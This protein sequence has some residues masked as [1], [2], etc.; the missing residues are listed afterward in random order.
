M[1]ILNSTMYDRSRQMLDVFKSIYQ[2][3]LLT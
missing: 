1:I 3:N 2:E